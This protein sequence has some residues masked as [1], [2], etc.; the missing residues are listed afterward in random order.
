MI[1]YLGYRPGYTWIA[2]LFPFLSHPLWGVHSRQSPVPRDC[3]LSTDV[4]PY[5]LGPWHMP[6]VSLCGVSPTRRGGQAGK[7]S[8]M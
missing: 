4:E 5:R 7:L 1:L 3:F 2:S 6:H 8:R